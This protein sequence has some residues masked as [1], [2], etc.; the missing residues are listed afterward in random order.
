MKLTS[1][2]T[3]T[4]YNI[5]ELTTKGRQILGFGKPATTLILNKLKE[6]KFGKSITTP[7][8]SRPAVWGIVMEHV[9]AMELDDRYEHT[10]SKTVKHP[11]PILSE[12]WLGRVDFTTKDSIAECKA[13]QIA[14]FI[15]YT[16][17]ILS[18]DLDLFKKSYRDEYWQI[19]SGA[20]LNNKKYGEAISFM[21]NES[22]F[23][24][25]RT[26][27]EE[28]NFTEKF[29]KLDPWKVRFITEERVYDLPVL[30]KH[31]Q[32]KPINKLRFEIPEEDKR[33]LTEC[34]VKALFLAENGMKFET[35][36]NEELIETLTTPLLQN[37]LA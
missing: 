17:T 20:I 24:N 35:A 10:G 19:V 18:G 29:L 4:S 2:V 14:G 21:P 31:S 16:E 23:E 12:H 36:T 6:V 8:Q 5:G 11:N 1:G 15:D 30:P 33:E 32:Y 3:F 34:V 9:L 22:M 7:Y 28:T 13:Y 37:L 27:I 25:V 26:L